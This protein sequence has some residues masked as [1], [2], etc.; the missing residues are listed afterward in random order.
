MD[1]VKGLWA[2]SDDKAA[3]LKEF[4]DARDYLNAALASIDDDTVIYPGWHKR[5]FIAHIVGWEAMC[6]EAFRSFLMGVPRRTYPFDNTL[7]AANEYFVSIRQ[8]MPLQD[9]SV[10]YEINHAIV[11]RFLLDIPEADYDQK[12]TFLWYAETVVQFIRGAVSHERNHADDI[13]A[14]HQGM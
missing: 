12:V 11:R 3:L 9:V 1:G 8:C 5:E 6:Y 10:E 2:V 7:D 4:D 13:R 14:L